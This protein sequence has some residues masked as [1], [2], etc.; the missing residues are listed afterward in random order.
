[1]DLNPLGRLHD[2]LRGLWG[3]GAYPSDGHTSQLP[4]G[5]NLPV[6]LLLH[7][8]VAFIRLDDLHHRQ[9]EH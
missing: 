1:M 9:C 3:D 7:R 5:G 8:I 2:W 4:I 6:Q